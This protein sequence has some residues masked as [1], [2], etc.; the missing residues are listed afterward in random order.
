M[1]CSPPPPSLPLLL[2][3][4]PAPAE[5]AVLISGA[6]M[7]RVPLPLR[8][9]CSIFARLS[10]RVEGASIAGASPRFSCDRCRL[11]WLA[12]TFAAW[13]SFSSLARTAIEGGPS[14]ARCKVPAAGAEPQ[15]VRKKIRRPLPRKGATR[16][17]GGQRLAIH[18]HIK[19]A[20]R[21]LKG[22]LCGVRGA[23]LR[24]SQ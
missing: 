2:L 19:P 16:D 12:T 3:R 20:V 18:D 4:M 14:I 11:L 24:G 15:L 21:Q 7:V 22:V 17:R 23:A 10:V 8:C 5:P 9:A 6:A 1:A 13:R